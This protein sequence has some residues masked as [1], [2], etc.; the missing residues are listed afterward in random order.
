MG[1]RVKFAES[2]IS[3]VCMYGIFDS[4]V[5]ISF[6]YGWCGGGTLQSGE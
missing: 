2:E 5:G 1:T 3:E 4:F 6:I